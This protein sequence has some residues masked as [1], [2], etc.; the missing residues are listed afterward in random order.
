MLYGKRENLKSKDRN[1]TDL[2]KKYSQ[3]DLFKEDFE[4]TYV[5][6]GG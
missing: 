2:C 3:K 6:T 4:S 5:I 1:E